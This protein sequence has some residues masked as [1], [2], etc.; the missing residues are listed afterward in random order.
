MASVWRGLLLFL[1]VLLTLATT[2]NA[3][4]DDNLTLPCHPDQ[5]ATLLEPFILARSMNDFGRYSMPAI[6]FERLTFLAH[7]NL[8]NSNFHGEI[9]IAIGKL[10]NLISL[11]LSSHYGTFSDDRTIESTYFP[12][13]LSV[14]NIQAIVGNLSN[15]RALYLDFV[16]IHSTGEEWCEALAKYVPR[17]QN[18]VREIERDKRLHGSIPSTIGNLTNLRR[19]HINEC[20]FLGPM[21]S[22]LG[23]LVNL[24]NLD[25]HGSDFSGPL[26]STIGFLRNLKSL[27]V[28]DCKFVGSI[29]YAVGQLKE[30]TRLVLR[31]SNFS[32]VIP[33]SI[34]NLTCL[35]ELDLSMNFL[36]GEILTSIF[37]LPALNSLALFDNQLSGPLQEFN[38]VSLSLVYLELGMNKLTGQI[39]RSIYELVGLRRLNIVSNN[40]T[41]ELSNLSVLILRS[42]QF[43]GSIDDVD[44]NHQTREHFS[45]LQIVDLASNNFSGS[46]SS[47]WFGRLK[48]M[49]EKF[50]STGETLYPQKSSYYAEFYKGSIEMAYKGSFVTFQRI[51][52][53]LTS[54][55]FSSNRLEGTIPESVGQLVSLHVLNMSHNAFKGKILAHLGSMTDLESLDLSCNQL[56]GGIP[57]ELADLTFLGMLN[58]SNNQLVGKVPQTHQ[59]STFENSSFEGNF[60]LCGPPLS[61]PCMVSPA[62]PS[63]VHMND[64]SHVDVVLYL[65]VGL[66]FGI[67]FAIAIVM[68]WVRISEWRVKS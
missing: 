19:L 51:L 23:N 34:G 17:L 31:G 53:T 68:T 18:S 24:R 44:G 29:P 39:P 13:S 2:S 62:P 25:I 52:T 4:G 38:V 12:N 16:K 28:E 56:S 6:G 3:H 9:P 47:E 11:D 8:S 7:L 21:P 14:S 63:P 50:N 20:G 27:Q 57:Q 36:S 15:L 64:S 45:S 40:F 42:N 41:G 54:I 37:I 67:G 22:S 58:L 49:M 65:F 61:N 33:S 55:D 10:E 43:N 48:S 35:L 30:L 1:A 5:A 46:L 59:F 26:P 60:G 66:G 32:G